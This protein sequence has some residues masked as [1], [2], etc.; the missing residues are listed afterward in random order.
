MKSKKIKTKKKQKVNKRKKSPKKKKTM[1]LDRSFFKGYEKKQK[2]F[3]DLLDKKIEEDP[4]VQKYLDG[5]ETISEEYIDLLLDN[6]AEEA[7][8][9]VGMSE[10]LKENAE[11]RIR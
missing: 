2:E 3:S 4:I 5:D 9:E 6:F 1:Y 10:W 7:R 11:K 8:I